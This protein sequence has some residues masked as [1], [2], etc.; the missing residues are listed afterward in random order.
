VEITVSG[1]M[2]GSSEDAGAAAG[3]LAVIEVGVWVRTVNAMFAKVTED[4]PLEGSPDRFV[5]VTVRVLV[6][7]LARAEVMTGAAACAMVATANMIV[8]AGIILPIWKR[9]LVERAATDFII[10]YSPLC[11]DKLV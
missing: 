8:K 9:L 5:P 1:Y 6:S 2:P 4:G 10:V 7:V 3:K 11:L